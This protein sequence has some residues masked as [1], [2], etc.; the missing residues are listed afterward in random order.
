M[1]AAPSSAVLVGSLRAEAVTVLANMMMA[2][3]EGG[4][5]ERRDKDQQCSPRPPGRD[6]SAA[7]VDGPSARA[8]RVDNRAGTAWPRRRALGW[9]SCWTPS[10]RLLA[11]K[12]ISRNAVDVAV[13]DPQCLAQ[14]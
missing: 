1:T 12:P 14:G 10:R 9:L 13:D 7:V 2:A 8:R 11:K 5:D 4:G 6:L 3:L